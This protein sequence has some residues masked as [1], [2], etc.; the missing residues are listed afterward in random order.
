MTKSAHPSAAVAHYGS[1]RRLSIPI[2]PENR[3]EALEIGAIFALRPE[4][5]SGQIDITPMRPADI[6]MLL[7]SN[8]FALNPTDF[9]LAAQ[10][11]H[12]A[13]IIANRIPAFELAYPRDFNQLRLI[14]DA[15]LTSLATPNREH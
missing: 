15:V 5:R 6:C 4:G 7:V 11:L 12:K 8:S 2:D 3:C 9:R 13:S 10:K 1:K 14:H